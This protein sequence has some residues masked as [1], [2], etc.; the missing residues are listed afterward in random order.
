LLGAA[1]AQ[2]EDRRAHIGRH[3]HLDP[4]ADRILGPGRGEDFFLA[5]VIAHRP[6]KER[7]L[8]LTVRLGGSLGDGGGEVGMVAA[9]A[10]DGIGGDFEEIGDVFRGEAVAA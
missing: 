10:G 6:L 8:D 4:H 5:M 9:P 3:P 7:A 1:V 2:P